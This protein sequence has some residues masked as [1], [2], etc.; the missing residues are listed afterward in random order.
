MDKLVDSAL[1]GYSGKRDVWEYVKFEP[2]CQDA[3]IDYTNPNPYTLR[4]FCLL[5]L[6]IA[7]QGL[8]LRTNPF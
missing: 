4:N 3:M 7:L 5:V 2:P 1:V 8:D 6:P